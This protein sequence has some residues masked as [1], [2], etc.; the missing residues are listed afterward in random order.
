M[1]MGTSIGQPSGLPKS[2]RGRRCTTHHH[3]CDCR[4]AKFQKIVI[5]N[6]S[7]RDLLEE[8]CPQLSGQN[9][10]RVKLFLKGIKE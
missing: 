9:Y 10:E 2:E 1:A 3:A 4:E 6:C 8:V 7:M 5:Q